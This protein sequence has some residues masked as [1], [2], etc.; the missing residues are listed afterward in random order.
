MKRRK[1]NDRS[2]CAASQRNLTE[3]WWGEKLFF[4]GNSDKETGK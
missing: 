4:N 2:F 3:N 1:E